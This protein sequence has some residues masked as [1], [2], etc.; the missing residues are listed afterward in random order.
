MIFV[1]NNFGQA[2]SFKNI[3]VGFSFHNGHKCDIFTRVVQ[4]TIIKWYKQRGNA[5]FSTVQRLELVV[6]GLGTSIESLGS[7]IDILQPLQFEEL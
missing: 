1:L 6:K 4:R 7:S 3:F 2:R 5:G